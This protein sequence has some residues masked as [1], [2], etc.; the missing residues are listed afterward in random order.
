MPTWKPQLQDIPEEDTLREDSGVEFEEEMEM[1]EKKRKE[2]RHHNHRTKRP[3]VHLE[4]SAT[5]YVRRRYTEG[6]ECY[7]TSNRTG[8]ELV[9]LSEELKYEEDGEV[10]TEE[11]RNMEEEVKE[12]D[13]EA[14]D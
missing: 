6:R 10:D 3:I 1:R 11:E 9:K 8:K 13:R 12:V 2:K 4:N 7:D 5:G 14:E